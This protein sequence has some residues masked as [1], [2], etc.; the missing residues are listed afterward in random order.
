MKPQKFLS[1]ILI[2]NF[3]SLLNANSQCTGWANTASGTSSN[4][5]WGITLDEQ[6]NSYV[7]GFCIGPITFGNTV[8][9]DTGLF[10]IKY[11][12]LGAQQWVK[13][14]PGD[15]SNIF[16]FLNYSHDGVFLIATFYS[17]V[18]FGATT[19]TTPG[20]SGIAVVKF[21]TDGEVQWAKTFSG[22]STSY[23][24][25]IR[26]TASGKVLI[27]GRY[28]GTLTMGSTT[29]TGPASG[30]CIYLSELDAANGNVLWAKSS[31]V[32]A[33][34]NGGRGYAIRTDG[35][36]NILLSGY[37]E[38][39]LQFGNQSLSNSGYASSFAPFVSKFDSSGNCQWIRGG[40]G[41]AIFD[42]AYGLATDSLN[43]VYFS[44]PLDTTLTFSGQSFN[45]V[46]GAFVIGK[47][48][49]SG[50]SLWTKQWGS[51][52]TDSISLAVSLHINHNNTLTAYGW[53]ENELIFNQDTLTSAGSADIFSA[54]F[55]EDGNYLSSFIT[56]NI[57]SE[58][59]YEVAYDNQDHAYVTGNFGDDTTTLGNFGLPGDAIT[60]SLEH[61]NIFVWK[62]CTG[63]GTV[64]PQAPETSLTIYPNPSDGLFF[65]EGIDGAQYIIYD[66]TGRI[67]KQGR[68]QAH[69]AIDL[70]NAA[71]G[72]Y[73][74]KFFNGGKTSLLKL[75]RE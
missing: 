6:N 41:P 45:P 51:H 72:I 25:G 73:V 58:T 20:Y 75:I 26:N 1:A 28:K 8:V 35:N 59:F 9:N 12:S 47:Y 14:F 15:Y 11:D 69:Q 74:M 54:D 39:I 21:N 36:H 13:S 19:L 5:S 3:I 27:T 24:Y 53:G 34:Y 17:S 31:T 48:D 44:C 64:I 67:V 2:L 60:D 10:V 70:S 63:V 42:N 38:N 16:S 65:I 33:N 68:V 18:T 7:A 71:P 46:N 29:L 61:S 66:I 56:G 32:Q 37:Y 49:A 43:N 62:N 52:I 23:G 50:N 55:D 57:H 22:T 40:T 30:Y 4:T